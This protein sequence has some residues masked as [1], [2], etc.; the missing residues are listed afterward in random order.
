MDF[1]EKITEHQQNFWEADGPFIVF[2]AIF[3]ALA[4]QVT[5]PLLVA[6]IWAGMLSF[7]VTP[8][9]R[10]V[11]DATSKKY[12]SLSAGI[13]LALLALL[14]IL[15]LVAVFA[16]LGKETSG[17]VSG[18]AEFMSRLEPGSVNDPASLIPVWT[19]RWLGDFLRSFLNDSDSLK[20][21]IQQTAQWTG[22][23]LT[24]VS[25]RLIHGASSFLFTMML[26]LM[27]SF[28][29]IR[30]G[31]KIFEYL[32]S[33][34]PLSEEEKKPFFARTKNLMN[35]VIYGILL[36]VALQAVLGGLGWWFVGL[37]SPAFFGMLMFFFGMFPAGTA[38]VW[39]PGAVYL[40]LTGDVKNGIILFVWGVAV[41]GTIDNFLR[42]FLISGGGN[43]EEIPTLLVILGLFGGV[44]AWGFL[45]IFLGP[46]ALVL[47][48]LVFDIYR[49]RQ[50]VR[51]GSAKR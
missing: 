41:V 35:S 2:F 47:F 26:V 51:S 9:F 40:L 25:K 20:E 39:V 29:F 23:F 45:G 34:T 32:K 27:V 46:L 10:R 15:P 13:T 43:G 28:F 30:D 17:L 1:N 37:G 18:V 19:P 5:R 11:N 4:W 24:D 7:T 50:L 3:A 31:E 38:V 12:P 44:I 33:V 16:T 22:G 21:L 14:F 36:T 48:T 49:S 6:V 8:V 42:P